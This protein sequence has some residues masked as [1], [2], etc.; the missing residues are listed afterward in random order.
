[1]SDRVDRNDL[2]YWFPL[3][4]AAGLPI[5]RTAIV[6][7]DA[8]L[9][10]LLDGE[11]PDGFEQLIAELA[12]AGDNLGWPC[13]LRTGHGSGKHEWASTCYVPHHR[14]LPR[15]VGALVEWSHLVD[16]MGLPT[17]T[18]AVRELLETRPLFTCAG[19]GGFPVVREFRVFVRDD[20]IEHLQPYW[21][22][23]AVE[24]GHPD[25]MDWRVLLA[26]ASAPTTRERLLLKLLAQRACYAVGGGYWS[27][28]MLE[29]RHH[30][31]WVIDMA[32]GDRSFRW[33][34]GTTT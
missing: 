21:P 29:D 32:D 6:H 24:Q 8:D 23:D 20:T 33:D 7:T 28:D 14:A 11:T 9:T 12:S 17:S 5:P 1:M 4:E 18:W 22:E 15:H 19:Y 25:L 34:P 3:I 13:F 30:A 31:W 10:S 16:L 26:E 2:A 27:V